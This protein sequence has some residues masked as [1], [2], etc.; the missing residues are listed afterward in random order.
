MTDIT[1]RPHRPLFRVLAPRPG[2]QEAVAA[3]EALL[4]DETYVPAHVTE[5]IRLAVAELVGCPHCLA[6]RK[7]LGNELLVDRELTPVDARRVDVS[8]QVAQQLYLRTGDLDGELL[9]DLDLVFDSAGRAQ[10]VFSA[11]YFLG[12][13]HLSK[14]LGESG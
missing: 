11:A 9:E 12:M 10:I 13:Q 4:W 1:E 5:H 3:V 8:T 6:E 14:A 2:L 7:M